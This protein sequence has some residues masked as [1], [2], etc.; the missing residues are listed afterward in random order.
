[1]FRHKGKRR[2]YTHNLR[3]ASMLSFVAGLVNV[4]GV[5]QLQV[6]TTNVT[7]HFAY[8]AENIV[9]NKYA[10]A[11]VLVFFVTSFL[12][13]AFCS[14]ILIELFSRKPVVSRYVFPIS[15]EII[16]LCLVALLGHTMSSSYLLASV[17]LFAMG[18]QNALVSRISNS[19]VRTTH[20]TG[21]F[22]DLGIELSLLF[23]HKR[24]NQNIRKLKQNIYL[25]FIII[26]FF[27]F[28]SIVGGF[29]TL[30]F[31]FKTLFVA[32]ICLVIAMSYDYFKLSY[33]QIKRRLSQHR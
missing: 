20:L 18:I 8:F 12:C 14:S 25:K 21:L 19:V 17:L 26:L 1:M 7:G 2:N 29:L 31:H 13:G 30:A 3:L 33:V 4:T 27:F 16:C 23:F 11:I 32:V 5:M 10:P 28:G 9:L 24:N 6:L 22:T 15:V